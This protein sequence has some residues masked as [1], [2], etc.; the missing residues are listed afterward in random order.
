MTD[1]LTE[2]FADDSG[3][4]KPVEERIR[5]RHPVRNTLIA[6][7]LVL[8]VAGGVVAMYLGSLATTVNS[9]ERIPNAFPEE[10][11]RPAATQ[12]D[13]QNILLIGSDSRGSIGSDIDDIAGD[14]AD[15]IMVVHIPADRS[16][17][18]VMSI[19]RDSWVDVPGHGEAKVNA[20]LA[21]G[22]VPLL[23]QTVEN[24]ITVRIDHVAVIDFDGFKGVTDALGGVT[25]NNSIAFESSHMKGQVYAD[26]PIHLSGSEALAFV[27]ERYAFADGD[28]QRARNQQAWLSGMVSAALS[29]D[30]LSNPVR[31]SDTV[32]AIAPYLALD[33]GADAGY[34]G[35]LGFSL[36]E[37]R[38]ADITMFTMPTAGTGTSPDGQ[39]I[40]NV[41]WDRLAVVQQ[42][43]RDDT[44]ADYEVGYETMLQ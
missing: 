2:L 43:F 1:R 24:L 6:L 28:F 10:A 8:L 23:V 9:V 36:R 7:A 20:A 12:T 16:G 14:R 3:P 37:L 35:T 39:S 34:L 21:W 5:R 40:V 13:A 41:D 4:T 30:T 18:Y 15:S 11:S 33:S 31:I 27:R 44:L 29:R 22:G 25:V 17:T 32:G 38:P 26:G 19:M 42:A